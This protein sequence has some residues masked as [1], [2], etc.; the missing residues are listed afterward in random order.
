MRCSRDFL[1]CLALFV[2]TMTGVVTPTPAAATAEDMSVYWKDGL[3]FRSADGETTMQIGG[4]INNDWA[5]F[6][7]DEGVE[8]RTQDGTEFRR[9]RISLKG[10]FA[11]GIFYKS[12]YDFGTGEIGFKDMYMGVKD[13]P[14]VGTF[15]VGQM[16]EPY[17]LEEMTSTN[18]I[19]LMERSPI[20]VFDSHRN[21]GFMLRN[22][23]SS[24]RVLAS[25]GVFR[26]TGP[27]GHG[28]GDGKY[29][30][31]VRV[32]GLPW[33]DRDARRLLHLGASGSY[34]S[35]LDGQMQ[36][37]LRPSSHMTSDI[38][39][40][41]VMETDHLT[42]AA[43][44]SAVVVGPFFAAAECKWSRA[45]PDEGKWP[46]I[47]GY[48][49][50][51]SWFLTGESHPYKHSVGGFGRVRPLHPFG[52]GSGAW[53]LAARFSHADASEF[54]AGTMDDYAVGL[55][56]Y[57]MDNARVMLNYVYTD[58]GVGGDF[59]GVQTRFMVYF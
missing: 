24:E 23:W 25:A 27:N 7:E 43:L 49:V 11:G 1:G 29:N 56:W 55:N 31:T 16:K 6:P 58:A 57:M 4:R 34:R 59:Q 22:G 54:D 21:T 10:T 40:T 5:W 20:A 9:A 52:K 50:S 26:Q 42:L 46:V 14:V 12:Q 41:A 36:Y 48:Y 3:H 8:V 39:E 33:E 37:T 2:F 35:T 51:A 17:S 28:V 45:E 47:W 30:Y 15:F 38:L 44:E 19:I 18:D 53:E 32:S 13:I